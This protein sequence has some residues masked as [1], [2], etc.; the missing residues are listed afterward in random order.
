[1]RKGY[2]RYRYIPGKVK[3]R[4]RL[5]ALGLATALATCGGYALYKHFSNK[6]IN[7]GKKLNIVVNNTNGVNQSS[8]Q[9][10]MMETE[11]I[12]PVPTAE[13][14]VVPKEEP[15]VRYVNNGFN[16]GD[17]VRAT[18][19]VNLRLGPS[20]DAFKV[21][22]LPKNATVDRIL[23][24]DN[25][26]LVKYNG[27]VAFVS[28]EFTQLSDVDYNNDY[29][30]VEEYNDVVRT[31]TRLYFRTGPSTNEPDI[32]LLNKKT[33]LVVI[34][35]AINYA[36]EN[37]VW[38]LAKYMDKI[39]FVKASYTTS[40]KEILQ[41]NDPNI[42]DLTIMNLAYVKNSTPLIN[43]KGVPGKKI[44]PYQLVKVLVDYDKLCLV[45]Y[46]D[47]IGYVNKD[48]IKLYKGTFVVVD[49]GDQRVFLY[50]N[51]D[52]IFED[53]CTTGKDATP[54]REGAFEVS[55]ITNSRY[56]SEDAEATVLWARFDDGNGLHDAEG[57]ENINNFGDRN[58]RKRKGS[59]GCVRLPYSVA[60][61]L[62]KI[63]KIGTKVLVK[64]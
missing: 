30:Y 9:A 58:Y 11:I 60:R 59:K 45:E 39:G 38:Y 43:S 35:K 21:G 37:D 34:G 42:T 6:A 57:W 23:S 24:T 53:V 56:F 14:T 18:A 51:T 46:E 48:D 15:L 4:R 2:R 62:K 44:V 10:P 64:R 13:P 36:D 29:Y 33:E 3:I 61:K 27:Q 7:S 32:C 19:N 49:L 50:C 26:D 31:T 5:M 16:R 63:I 22:E 28:S 17:S 55:E 40:L 20:T 47:N 12:T 41:N 52:M 1:M 54:T 25:W 8:T